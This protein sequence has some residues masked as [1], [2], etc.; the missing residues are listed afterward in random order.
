MFG[1]WK[2]TFKWVPGCL[3]SEH[4][5]W[6]A[7]LDWAVLSCC[8][9]SIASFWTR[10]EG[11]M[12]IFLLDPRRTF[13]IP[14]WESGVVGQIQMTPRIPVDQGSSFG[15]Q[16]ARIWWSLSVG[17][18]V[19]VLCPVFM[20]TSA[21]FFAEFCLLRS[22]WFIPWGCNKSCCFII[23]SPSGFLFIFFLLSASLCFALF[24]V[25]VSLWRE[26]GRNFSGQEI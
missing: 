13:L 24:P 11:R 20:G 6:H 26:M 15:W 1:G 19:P 14:L 8:L 25:T 22:Y 7:A 2:G 10:K 17:W 9:L 16:N 21:D 4:A 18:S 12:H 5:R 3:V 23:L